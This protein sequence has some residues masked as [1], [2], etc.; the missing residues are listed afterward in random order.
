MTAPCYFSV[1]TKVRVMRN[2]TLFL[3]LNLLLPFAFCSVVMAQ[4]N[5]VQPLIDEITRMNRQIQAL[6]RNLY[7]GETNTSKLPNESALSNKGKEPSAAVSQLQVKSSQLGEQVRDLTGQFEELGHKI[8]LVK[9]RLDK[10]VADVDYRL[11]ALEEAVIKSAESVNKEDKR[12][13]ETSNSVENDSPVSTNETETSDQNQP[14]NGRLGTLTPEQRKAAQNKLKLGSS[15]NDQQEKNTNYKGPVLPAGSMQDRYKYARGFLIRRDYAGAEKALKAFV[16]TYPGNELSGNAHYWLGETFYV[17]EDFA[18]AARTFAE[19]FQRYP[20][21]K[22]APDNLLKLGMSLS[23]LK[24]VED[25]CITLDKLIKEYPN[26][27]SSIKQRTKTERLK[28]K[29]N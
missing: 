22:K 3:F 18:S 4:S 26:S 27:P 6:E 25:A 1:L 23:A 11:R 12:Q 9:D 17:R 8:N 14:G 7:R 2:T 29:C 15:N 10:L 24:R 28:L 13:K 21:N 16:D 5:D 19:G 20:K